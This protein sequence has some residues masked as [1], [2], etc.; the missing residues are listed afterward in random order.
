[1]VCRQAAESAERNF[2]RST[3]VRVMLERSIVLAKPGTS[4]AIEWLETS[5]TPP[6]PAPQG[7]LLP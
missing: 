1:M 4:R 6:S 2:E 7:A 3:L 5:G